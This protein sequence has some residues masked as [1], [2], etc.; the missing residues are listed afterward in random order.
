MSKDHFTPW[1]PIRQPC[2]FCVSFDGITA[3]GADAWCGLPGLARVRSSPA[4]GC[5]SFVREV[6][7]DDEPDA[8]PAGF[9][10]RAGPAACR[11]GA[12][13]VVAAAPVA[14]PWAP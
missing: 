6:G 4:V 2:W 8:V 10:S 9:R 1:Q 11:T 12:P 14:V 5:S 13:V 7:A 3:S